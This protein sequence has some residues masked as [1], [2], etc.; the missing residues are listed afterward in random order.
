MI[1]NVSQLLWKRQFESDQVN[2]SK[3]DQPV[4]PNNNTSD[5]NNKPLVFKPTGKKYLLETSERDLQRFAKVKFPYNRI[6]TNLSEQKKYSTNMKF[7]NLFGLSSSSSSSSSSKRSTSSTNSSTTNN[8]QKG[9]NNQKLIA[10][11]GFLSF[12]SKL[13]VSIICIF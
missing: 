6:Q 10:T 4:N 5:V 12:L 9:K 3:C 2:F 1:E 7:R 13:Y 8:M 11:I